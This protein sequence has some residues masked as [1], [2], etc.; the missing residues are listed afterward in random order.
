MPTKNQAGVIQ[1]IVETEVAMQSFAA[2]QHCA[3]PGCVLH[4]S[5]REHCDPNW[6]IHLWT[7]WYGRREMGS[8]L[9][10]QTE[11]IYLHVNL[12]RDGVLAYA[13]RD[14]RWRSRKM[15]YVCS[16]GCNVI[17]LCDFGLTCQGVYYWDNYRC[18]DVPLHGT[19][20]VESKVKSN[21]R[22]DVWSL[23]CTI[24]ELFTSGDVW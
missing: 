9:Y 3:V 1:A 12:Q 19:G 18:L 4:T 13:Q 14:S 11:E 7:K 8:C 2:S 21:C 17:K 6:W 24:A 22:T 5:G 15:C 10:C 20:T 16:R 23:A